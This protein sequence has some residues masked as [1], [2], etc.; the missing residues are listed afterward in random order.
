MVRIATVNRLPPIERARRTWA[1]DRHGEIYFVLRAIA[2][3]VPAAKIRA[4]ARRISDE[5]PEHDPVDMRNNVL[6]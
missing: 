3:G 6:T 4:E 1:A 5:Y 2:V